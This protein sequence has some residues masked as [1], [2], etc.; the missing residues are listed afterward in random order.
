MQRQ[1]KKHGRSF[2]LSTKEQSKWKRFILKLLEACYNESSWLWHLRFG[3][4][5]FG[6]LKLLEKKEIV[7]GLPCI[8]QPDQ[9]CEGCLLGNQ[10]QRS[11]L[12]ESLS[13]ATTTLELIQTNVCGPIKPN[14]FVYLV[15]H[16]PTRSAHEKTPQ[17]AWSGRKLGISHLRVFK[18]IAYVHV[19]DQKRTKLDD[20]SEK[21]IF[22]GYDS[23]SKGYKLY[24]LITSKTII[25]RD[26]KFDEEDSW[27]WNT[28]ED[29][30]DFLPYIEE[31]DVVEKLRMEEELKE[32]Y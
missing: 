25:N 16:S 31:E 1:P 26:V 17:E 8:N 15:N 24:N 5:N 9:L 22:I 14:S 30:H 28:E 6:G 4:L 10:S 7:R 12:K 20:K 27:D 32:P 11:F 13:R 3:H 19:P 2:K 29:E 21:Y 18:S 23:R